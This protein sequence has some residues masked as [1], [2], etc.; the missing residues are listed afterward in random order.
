MV[1]PRR[2]PQRVTGKHGAVSVLVGWPA[3]PRSGNLLPLGE[4]ANV[5]GRGFPGIE[6]CRNPVGYGVSRGA[7]HVGRALDI[8]PSHCQR[9][10]AEQIAHRE[11]VGAGKRGEGA[12]GM[13]QI[14]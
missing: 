2:R 7:H 4:L 10:M 3:Y 5:R 12:C 13:S 6:R 1:R 9:A 14:V 8:T 11:G